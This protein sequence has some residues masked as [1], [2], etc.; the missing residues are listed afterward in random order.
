[1]LSEVHFSNV[2]AVDQERF[3]VPRC[4]FHTSFSIKMLGSEC[5]F[6]S[7]MKEYAK[8][9]ERTRCSFRGAL[10][11]SLGIKIM[12]GKIPVKFEDASFD[13]DGE[14]SDVNTKST[15]CSKELP[16]KFV[17]GAHEKE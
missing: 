17:Y 9:L 11:K 7:Q 16:W 14:H 1:M 5:F 3:P 6:L 13:G 8:F 4:T 10:C 12:H 15:S 2:T